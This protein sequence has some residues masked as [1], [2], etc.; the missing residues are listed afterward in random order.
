[1]RLS[2]F[3]EFLVLAQYKSFSEAADYL[4]ISQSSLSKHIARI[5]EELGVVLI[6]RTSQLELTEAGIYFVN[7][8]NVMLPQYDSLVN[9][10]RLLG[11]GF[12]GSLRIGLLYYTKE[13]MIP[14]IE[15]FVRQYP[16]IKIDYIFGTPNDLYSSLFNNTIDLG[17]AMNVK[18]SN[19]EELAAVN[20]YDEQIVF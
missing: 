5:E 15:E 20:L 11:E 3:K 2:Y 12:N 1:M 16:K 4:Y 6:N 14:T 8:L 13:L 19:K 9:E 10:I 7:W 18:T 17:F